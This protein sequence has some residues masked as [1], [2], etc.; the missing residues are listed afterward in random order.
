LQME[1]GAS[2]P[3]THPVKLLALSYGLMPSID[4]GLTR[5]TEDLVTT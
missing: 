3:T 4:Q 1:Q 2:K 5:R